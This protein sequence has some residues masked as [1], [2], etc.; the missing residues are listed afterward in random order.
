MLLALAFHDVPDSI[1]LAVIKLCM[2]TASLQVSRLGS[3][4]FDQV[5]KLPGSVVSRAPRACF[6]TVRRLLRWRVVIYSLTCR[7]IGRTGASLPFAGLELLQ[8]S[9]IVG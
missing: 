3:A 7:G 9:V 5:T 6:I 2:Q 4:L 8:R 1:L